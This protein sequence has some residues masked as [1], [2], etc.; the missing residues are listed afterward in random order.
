ML[1]AVVW[2][3]V[4]NLD[5]LVVALVDVDT[6]DQPQPD[7][8]S[9][10]HHLDQAFK[11]AFVD[12]VALEI[13]VG[14]EVVSMTEEEA[15]E[16]VVASAVTEEGLVAEEVLA[17]KIAAGFR[18]VRHL[19][20]HLVDPAPEVA[21][22]RARPTAVMT[23]GDAMDTVETDVV[24]EVA[25]TPEILVVLVG[26]TETLLEMGEVGM[27]TA[28]DTLTDPDETK[29]MDPGSDIT[30]V[31]S[32]MIQDQSGGIEHHIPIEVCWWV[33]LF[34]LFDFCL[35]PST[36]RVRRYC[37]IINNYR[38]I[39][40]GGLVYYTSRPSLYTGPCYYYHPRPSDLHT[41]QIR[42]NRAGSTSSYDQRCAFDMSHWLKFM[43]PQAGEPLL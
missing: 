33:S 10:E 36:S 9:V 29:I 5:A 11:E 27:V 4:G 28:I 34:Q 38:T 43:F 37:I 15:S 18:T 23:T 17:I 32:M 21:S 39:S 13:E 6:Q 19:L 8:N 30:R 7:H 40:Q 26:A 1:N 42:I 20:V 24:E 41:M 14:S 22:D 2:S 25:M 31:N 12:E 35:V 16:D 3:R